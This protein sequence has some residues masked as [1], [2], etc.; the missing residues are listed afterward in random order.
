[1]LSQSDGVTTVFTDPVKRSRSCLLITSAIL[2]KFARVLPFLSQKSASVS[3]STT[4]RQEPSEPRLEMG[5]PS[6][7]L[8][9]KP[10]VLFPLFGR[11]VSELL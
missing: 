9:K 7:A 11:F 3:P 2:S 10:E 8:A 5:M 1:M 4:P 6:S